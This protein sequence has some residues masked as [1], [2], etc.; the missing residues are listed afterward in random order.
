MKKPSDFKECLTSEPLQK[1]FKSQFDLVRYA[2]KLAEMRVKLGRD[3]HHVGKVLNTAYEVLSDI[4]DRKDPQVSEE[5]LDEMI[6]QEKAELNNHENDTMAN[7]AIHLKK[8]PTKKKA[9][10]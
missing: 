8:E 4:A 10:L 3:D 6:A 7:E 2:I 5:A 1:R 9:R